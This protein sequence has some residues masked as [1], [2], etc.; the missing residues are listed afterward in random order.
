MK[1]FRPHRGNFDA[2]RR[3]EITVDGI[4]RHRLADTQLLDIE[5]ASHSLVVTA[6]PYVAESKGVVADAEQVVICELSANPAREDAS[7]R[8]SV[9]SEDD[10]QQRVL[11][12]DRPPYSGGRLLGMGRGILA[13]GIAFGFALLT[14]GVLIAD[15]P[16]LAH[17]A[18]IPAFLFLSGGGVLLVLAAAFAGATGLRSLYYYFRLPRD[19][20]H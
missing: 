2:W 16:K 6:G 5:G 19:W 13:V 15:L 9:V 7:V 18:D 11:R 10:A 3:Y 12:F 1:I 17:P 14:L 20:R 8:L 4:E